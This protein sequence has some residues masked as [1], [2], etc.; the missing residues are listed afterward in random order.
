[1]REQQVFRRVW[2]YL[3]VYR[4]W[5]FLAIF[6][7]MVSA[8]MSVLEPFILGLVITELSANLMDM[9]KG[10]EGAAINSS[11]IA[12]LLFVYM[13]RA[14]FFELGAYGSNYFLIITNLETC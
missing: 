8:T 9:A 12:F 5:V 11:H 13:V 10:I 14:L 1:M 4:L 2:S 6:L 7:K 3:K